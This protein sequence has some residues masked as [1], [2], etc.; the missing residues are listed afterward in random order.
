MIA[1]SVVLAAISAGIEVWLIAYAGLLVDL[2]GATD[3]GSLWRDHGRELL[4]AAA[5]VLIARPLVHLVREAIDDLVLKPNAL[6]RATWRAHR[7]VSLQPV[8]WFRRDLAGRT[9]TWVR[10]S[11]LPARVRHAP[12]G[13]FRADRAARR[14]VCERRHA[15]AARRPGRRGTHRPPGVR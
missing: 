1:A 13:E 6:T 7:Y 2:L 12:G 8:G 3:P 14:L 9:A 11:S 15:G 10:D 5:L 4:G